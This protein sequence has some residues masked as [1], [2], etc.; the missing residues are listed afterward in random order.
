MKKP[1]SRLQRKI[2]DRLEAKYGGWWR[3]IWGGPFQVGGLPDLFGCVSGIFFALEVKMPGRKPSKLQEAE[4]EAIQEAGGYSG[5]VTSPE[6]ACE[7]VEAALAVAANS[8]K[9]KT[10]SIPGGRP[11]IRKGAKGIRPVHGA[12]DR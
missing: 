11:G 12:G 8:A 1:E 3:K 2:R 10:L 5:V 6:E 4:I 9:D 7:I